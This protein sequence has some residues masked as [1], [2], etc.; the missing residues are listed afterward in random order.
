MVSLVYFFHFFN[1]LAFLPWFSFMFLTY[2]HS[3]IFLVLYS[4]I[5]YLCCFFVQPFLILLY[6]LPCF[7]L[8]YFLA[9]TI[10]RHGF[11]FLYSCLLS[12]SHYFT[13]LLPC[14][15]DSIFL[16][17]HYI[18][19][20]FAFPIS[21]LT[22]LC[23]ILSSNLFRSVLSLSCFLHASSRFLAHSYHGPTH[24]ASPVHQPPSKSAC[25]K[26]FV[27]LACLPSS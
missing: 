24:V 4:F 20:G 23:S 1:F 2:C 11:H 13:F 5:S 25:E 21:I 22:S 8:A 16:V 7:V 14:F 27:C 6:L 10:P 9:F 18:F 3:L 19:V 12:Y 15:L 26:S 17:L